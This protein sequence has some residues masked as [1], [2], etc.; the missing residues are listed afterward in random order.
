MVKI[1]CVIGLL[2]LAVSSA[3]ALSCSQAFDRCQQGCL[4]H[5]LHPSE[6]VNVYCLNAKNE[7]VRT[8]VFSTP[9]GGT[10]C[11]NCAKR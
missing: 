4:K 10:T 7:C 1:G 9:K 3:N 5:G 8:G 6:C 2:M 11:D